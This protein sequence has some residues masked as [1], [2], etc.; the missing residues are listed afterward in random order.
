MQY[1]FKLDKENKI[2]YKT[3]LT[4][5]IPI[6]IQNLLSTLI[7]MVDTI[8]VGGLGEVSVAAIGIA[9]QY[10]FLY[11]M[12]LSGIIGGAGLFI[13]QFFGKNDK[14]NIRKITALGALSAITLGI[15]FGT[16]A[17]LSPKFIIHF[18]SLDESVIEIAANYFLIIGFCY[19]I[20]AI[21]NVFSMGSRSIRNPKLGMICSSISLGL[22]IILNYIFIFGKFGMPALG[23]SGAA[24]ATVISRIVELILLVSYV[25][26]IKSDYELRFTFK[27]IKLINK[28][29]FKA[30][31][32][33][34]IPV[35][36]N[37][38]L[39]A[40]GTVLYAVAYSKAGTSA[41]AAS[42]I[43]SST[44][45]FF[46]MTSVCIAIGSSIMIGNELGADHI[47]KAVSYSKKFAILVCL[48]G[49][50]FGGLLIL[51]IP[52]LLKVFSVSSGLA[53]DIKKIFIIMGVLMAL[54][55]FN[56][57]IIIGVLRS[58]G[59]TK[60]ALTLEMGCMWFV[61]LPL[62]FFAA[63]KGVPIYVLVALTYTE[64]I[65]KFIF[66]VPRAL[67]KKWANNIVKDI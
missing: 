9:N 43:A 23:A 42:Q 10:F 15:I 52:A 49:L 66:G 60:Y 65:A 36:F 6:I 51:S 8:M 27:D 54:K 46:I 19:P 40:F 34:T 57:F 5:C 26:F 3:L 37:D 61:S 7:N 35:F 64:E 53:P 41:I 16:L 4:L 21:S 48:V 13:A 33:K 25:Y 2:F 44:G 22:N 55:T 50:V 63:Y 12:A 31:I 32:S 56:T 62:T 38:T 17:I 29:L 59:D 18:F 67:S 39:W 1:I 11:N 24:L 14:A 58:G 28:D 30:F 20:I 45:N 47:E